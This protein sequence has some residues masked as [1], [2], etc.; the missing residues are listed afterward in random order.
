M[1]ENIVDDDIY[2]KDLF[3]IINEAFKL[4]VD[5]VR[6]YTDIKLKQDKSIAAL[7]VKEFLRKT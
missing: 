1:Y 5:S 4:I 6:S 3:F 2:N 7:I